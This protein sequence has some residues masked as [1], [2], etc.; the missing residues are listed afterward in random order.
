MN[1]F[2]QLRHDVNGNTRFV[3]SWLGFGFNSYA[4][5]VKAANTLGGRKYHCKAYGGGIVFQAYQ[6]ELADISARLQALAKAA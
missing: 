4:Q 2:K 1:N 3:T 5:A 6:C